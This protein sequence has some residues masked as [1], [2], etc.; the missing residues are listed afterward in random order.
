MTQRHPEL[1]CSL[2][3]HFAVQATLRRR[4]DNQDHT[5]ARTS[6]TSTLEEPRMDLDNHQ[7]SEQLYD[8]ILA[9]IAEFTAGERRQQSW[10]ARHFYLAILI[11]IACLVAIW[12]SPHNYVSFLLMLLASLGLASGVVDGLIAL[13]FFQTEFK[14]LSEF[15]WDI[16]NAKS[17]LAQANTASFS[18]L[19]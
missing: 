5:T 13:L 8:E 6:T 11:W 17:L 10:R 15:E 4:T 2:S 1:L 16:R 12:F 14:A 9:M 7:P 18:K 3:D 19:N